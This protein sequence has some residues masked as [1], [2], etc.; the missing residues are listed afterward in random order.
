MVTPSVEVAKM[1]LHLERAML[2]VLNTGS[3][4]KPEKKIQNRKLDLVK[5][6]TGILSF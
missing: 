2:S 4:P 1:G 5:C 3:K 6:K